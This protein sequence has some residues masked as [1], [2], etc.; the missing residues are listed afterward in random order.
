MSGLLL[1]AFLPSFAS[2]RDRYPKAPCPQPPPCPPAKPDRTYEISLIFVDADRA[3]VP[4][5]SA[6]LA[7]TSNSEEQR[8]GLRARAERGLRILQVSGGLTL[9][10][11]QD[12]VGTRVSEAAQTRVTIHPHLNA[13]CAEAFDFIVEPSVQSLTR[14]GARRSLV[15]ENGDTKLLNEADRPDGTR[16][17]LYATVFFPI[18]SVPCLRRE[19]GRDPRL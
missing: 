3:A 15:F 8:A 19:D 11:P 12:A 5:V 1:S 14:T 2:G 17:L 10:V 4:A 13:D 16:R 9:R 18:R 6:F 7:A